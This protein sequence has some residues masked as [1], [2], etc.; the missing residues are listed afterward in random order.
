[1]DAHEQGGHDVGVGLI[2]RLDTRQECGGFFVSTGVLELLSVG[3][4]GIG[5]NGLR[6]EAGQHRVGPGQ[7]LRLDSAWVGEHLESAQRGATLL[8]DHQ[9]QLDQT[10]S[11]AACIQGGHGSIVGTIRAR[12][13]ADEGHGLFAD[14]VGVQGGELRGGQL[15]MGVL[16]GVGEAGIHQCPAAR[17]IASFPGAHGLH[18]TVSGGGAIG[19]LEVG[20]SALGGGIPA[21]KGLE[22]PVQHEAIVGGGAGLLGVQHLAEASLDLCWLAAPEDVLGIFGR[23]LHAPDPV[24]ALRAGQAGGEV[25]GRRGKAGVEGPDQRQAL[26]G[27]VG[28]SVEDGPD[29]VGIFGLRWADEQHQDEDER[30]HGESSEPARGASYVDAGGAWHRGGLVDSWLDGGVTV[31]FNCAGDHLGEHVAGE[32]DEAVAAARGRSVD[33]CVMLFSFTH[34]ELAGHLED[35]VRTGPSVRVHL[36]TDWTQLPDGGGRQPPRL[37]RAGLPGLAVRFKKDAPYAWDPEAGAVVYDRYASTGLNHHKAVI[38]VVGGLPWR[39]LVGSYNW[40]RSADEDNYENLVCVDA[41]T[42]ANRSVIRRYLAEFQAL[43]NDASASLSWTEALAH[44]ATVFAELE[45]GLPPQGLRAGGGDTLSL[46]RR[47]EVMDLNAPVADPELASWLGGAGNLSGLVEERR[48]SGAFRG[49]GDLLRRLPELRSLPEEALARLREDAVF[50]DGAPG[51]QV[52]VAFSGRHPHEAVGDAGF[53]ELNEDWTVPV[54]GEDGVERVEAA[55]LGAGVVDLLRRVQPGQTVLLAM[56]GLSVRTRSWGAL[57][58]AV[59]RGVHVRVVLDHGHTDAAQAA[60]AALAADGHAVS[61]HVPRRTMHE[62][63]MVWVEGRDVV[64]G[65]ASVSTSSETRHAEARLFFYDHPVLADA[66]V[67]EFERLW[68]TAPAPSAPP[69]TELPP[70]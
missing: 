24:A 66:F 39:L 33:V 59:H 64:V 13:G 50:G 10:L 41:G 2:A 28:E 56:Y 5:P 26:V 37:A 18:A 15:G 69:P 42:A 7:I 45:A 22:D 36:L 60:L 35:L 65:T 11:E 63:F 30:A 44:K 23:P 25:V 4:G 49:M 12:R 14:V 17:P 55:T 51:P 8:V 52:R 54:V 32:L 43:W 46:V 19:L 16:G 62:K 3:D 34:A 29:V 31:H 27:L 48:R 47:P 57:E 67:E 38:L 6:T 70:G 58:A 68:L 1:M 21:G 9:I 61:V 40:S 20:G 53:A